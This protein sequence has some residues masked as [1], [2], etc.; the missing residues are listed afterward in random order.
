MAL[1]LV[2]DSDYGVETLPKTTGLEANP[3]T[4][5]SL[6]MNFRLKHTDKG[7]VTM[8]NTGRDTNRSLFA[9]C[10]DKTSWLDG[11]HV[12]FGKVV[13]SYYVLEAIE[14][15]GSKNGSP[16]AKVIIANCGQIK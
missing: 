14:A 16:Q 15:K 2:E 12:V 6:S 5:R 7:I 9:I 8:V 3:S 13:D 10:L 4:G 11:K 1:C